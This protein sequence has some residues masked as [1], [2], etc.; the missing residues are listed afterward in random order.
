MQVSTVKHGPLRAQVSSVCSPTSFL[1]LLKNYHNTQ[2]DMDF[3]YREELPAHFDSTVKMSALDSICVG[4]ELEFMV[5][6]Q[7]ADTNP[8]WN[9]TRWACP[10]SPE[11]YMG[12]VMGDYTIIKPSH[13]QGLRHNRQHRCCRLV[14]LLPA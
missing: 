7:I 4:I 3:P 1:L 2:A 5:A 12:L 11:A 6:L 9:E 14:R 13:P 8:A 10:S